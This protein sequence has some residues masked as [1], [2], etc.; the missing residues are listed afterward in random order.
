[1]VQDIVVQTPQGISNISW[2]KT[3]LKN[4]HT[5]QAG[6]LANIAK[7]TAK[8]MVMMAMTC[9]TAADLAG[10]MSSQHALANTPIQKE[11]KRHVTAGLPN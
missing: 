6:A 5:P 4:C 11:H 10:H 1:M 3:R 9:Q 8:C 7:V 2:Q